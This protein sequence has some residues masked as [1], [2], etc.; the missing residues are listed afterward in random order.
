MNLLFLGGKRFF[1]NKILNK[2]IQNNNYNIFVVYRKKKPTIKKKKK[3]IFV[4]CERNSEKDIYK[5]LYNIKFDIIYDNNC[6]SLEN[7]KKI[8][9]NLKN[10]NYIYIFIS[11]IMTYM[12]NDK[13]KVTFD[14]DIISRLPATTKKYIREKSKVEK[15]LIKSGIKFVIF[16]L[17]NLI[18]KNDFSNKTN[19]LFNLTYNDIKKFQ[20]S[21]NDRIQFAF[22]NDVVKIIYKNILN[23]NLKK[24]RRKIVTI[25]NK[26]FSLKKIINSRKN[27]KNNIKKKVFNKFPFILNFIINKNEIKFQKHSTLKKILKQL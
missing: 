5:K 26:S 9:F 7:C 12:L 6:Y 11:S 3:V 2:L 14:K 17:H 24:F 22:V 8:L 18:G 25:S 16:R 13:S 19:F 23:L 27:F 15:Y 1:G 10:Q 4:K 21:S 20:I